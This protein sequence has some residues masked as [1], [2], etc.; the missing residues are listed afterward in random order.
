MSEEQTSAITRMEFNYPKKPWFFALSCHLVMLGLFTLF[1]SGK[2]SGRFSKTYLIIA[3]SYAFLGIFSSCNLA[4]LFGKRKNAIALDEN[5]LKVRDKFAKWEEIE[6][7]KD[8]PWGMRKSVVR[9]KLKKKKMSFFNWETNPNVLTILPA[10]FVY[11]NVLPAISTIRP[12]IPIGRI[13]KKCIA[14]PDWAVAPDRRSI[15]FAILVNVVLSCALL[16]PRFQNIFDYV[17]IAGLFGISHNILNIASHSL[18]TT[19]KDSFIKFALT[20]PIL[21]LAVIPLHAMAAVEYS[22]L[23]GLVIT[24]LLI[25]FMAI[26]ALFTVKDLNYGLQLA[27]LCILAG[28][29]AGTY[30]YQKSQQWP[31]KDVS[32]LICG[33]NTTLTIWGNRGKNITAAWYDGNGCVIDTNTL[34]RTFLPA[35]NGKI[36]TVWL[37]ERFLVRD[38]KSTDNDNNEPANGLWVYDFAKQQEFQMPTSRKYSVGSRR[39]V[40]Y[41]GQH[42]AWI[43][44]QQNV[45]KL[46]FYNI[47][48]MTEDIDVI[49]LPEDVNLSGGKPRWLGEKEIAILA[50]QANG[51]CDKKR[52][53][54]WLN[55]ENGQYRLFTSSQI[56]KN[57]YST[58]DFRY[59]LG[60]NDLGNDRYSVSFVDLEKNKTISLAG[61]NIPLEA[62]EARRLF[63]VVETKT[64]TYLAMFEFTSCEDKLLCRVPVSMSVLG[65]SPTGKYVLLGFDKFLSFP[66]YTVINTENGKQHKIHLPGFSGALSTQYIAKMPYFSRFS[67]DEHW[68]MLETLETER[69]LTLLIKIPDNW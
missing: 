57:W 55:I 37:D 64:G 9:I 66:I 53:V 1:Y 26:L 8:G 61:E 10:L 69:Q 39:P 22:V 49:E 20:C 25:L 28:A 41:K 46:R 65:V 2:I 23:E 27:I 50:S 59:A 21:L 43:D 6:K 34:K 48:T 40:D 38:V 63:H 29:P 5:G 24:I 30:F 33:D 32:S 52:L 51:E 3:V 58:T 31:V 44:Y 15:T 16:V 14:D 7:I 42:L 17:V 19:T 12:D 18:G 36:Y 54:L 56:Y 11:C 35:H 68:L 47:E 60:V 62:A 4:A 45:Q 13:T 67:P